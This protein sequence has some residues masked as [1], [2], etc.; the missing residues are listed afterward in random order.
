MFLQCLNSKLGTC[1]RVSAAW[2][3]EGGDACSVNMNHVYCDTNKDF[4]DTFHSRIRISLISCFSE[5]IFEEIIMRKSCLGKDACIILKCSL[6]LR[7]S[8][9][10]M[11]ARFMAF[12]VI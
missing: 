12:F 2:L 5:V 6:I 10:L 1:R 9:F 7:L 8:W 3:Q 11:T 4:I